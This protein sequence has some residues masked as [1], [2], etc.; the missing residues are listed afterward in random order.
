MTGQ[1]I[2]S[3]VEQLTPASQALGKQVMTTLCK[4]YP[5]FKDYWQVSINQA[6]GTVAVT[7]RALSGKMGFMLHTTQID[8]EGKTVMRAGGELLERYAVLRY[9]QLSID[10]ALKNTRFDRLGQMQHHT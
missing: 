8:P 1:I 4:Y 6:G 9:P 5:T 3:T 7:N 2:S 10:G